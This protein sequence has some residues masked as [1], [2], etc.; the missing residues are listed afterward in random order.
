MEIKTW[1]KL[2]EA[3]ESYC[4]RQMSHYSI[5][6]HRFSDTRAARNFVAAQPS[7][8]LILPQ[9]G[10]AVFLEAKFSEGHD[11]LRQCFAAAVDAQQL[12]SARLVARA[13]RDYRVLFYS[14]PADTFELWDGLYLADMKASGGRLDL[15]R[16]LAV[17]GSLETILDQ[18][19]LRLIKFQ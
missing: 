6:F 4:R 3:I 14:R 13:K 17:L 7:D 12:A 18:H 10:R 5:Y 2:E 19:I 15:T 9:S 8:F 11:S 16:R 1:K